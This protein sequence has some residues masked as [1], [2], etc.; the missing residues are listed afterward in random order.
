MPPCPVSGPRREFPPEISLDRAWPPGEPADAFHCILDGRAA[1]GA[2]LQGGVAE[3]LESFLGDDPRV[4]A[5]GDRVPW[6]ESFAESAAILFLGPV[7][8][9]RRVG[10]VDPVGAPV[11]DVGAAPGDVA[12]G[13]VLD[14]A[15]RAEARVMA[16]LPRRGL[17]ARG[18]CGAEL[19]VRFELRFGYRFSVQGQDSTGGVTPAHFGP[20]SVHGRGSPAPEQLGGGEGG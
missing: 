18:A 7:A 12:V 16:A 20:C 11:E 19:V 13:A 15:A 17:G 14:V 9:A 2:E 3:E 6:P 5:F 1:A 4:G 10:G 8:S